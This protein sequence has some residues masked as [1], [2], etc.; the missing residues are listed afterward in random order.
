M[1]SIVSPR[2]FVLFALA[3]VFASLGSAKGA[4]AQ[5][6]SAVETIEAGQLTVLYSP[7]AP[8][9][10]FILN[11][12]P[13]GMAI[14]LVTEAARRI[15]LR[16]VFRAQADL[17]G[18]VP[19]VSNRQYDLA[20]IG[21]MRTPERE[22]IV[23]FTGSWYYGWFPLV[24]DKS[25][26][27]KGYGDMNGKIVGVIR[28]SIQ[29]KYMQDNHPRIK[30]MGFPNEVAMINAAN[31]GTID[32][33]LMGSAQVEETQRR[34]PNL[35]TIERTPTPYPNAFPIRKG[36]ATLKNALDRALGEMMADGTYVKIFDK[37]HPGDALPD[38][39]YQ[40]YPA[41]AQQRK[42]GVAAPK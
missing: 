15:G 6:A 1:R 18:A 8:P 21:L 3:A 2:R 23:D 13:T 11:G 38:P 25:R 35:E 16:P 33:L 27:F 4:T 5:S 32:G 14:D 34:F 17:A 30:L 19:A 9:T 42:P 28:G 7:S 20:A 31:A 24:V 22:A 40:D 37:W 26:G 29:D 39:L 10:S 12:Q 41:L 36:N